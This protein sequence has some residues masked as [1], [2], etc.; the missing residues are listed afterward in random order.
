MYR[1]LA[2]LSASLA[3]IGYGRGA[4]EALLATQPMKGCAT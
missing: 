2:V 1:S 3:A 4:T